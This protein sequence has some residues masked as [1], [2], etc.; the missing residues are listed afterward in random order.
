MRPIF[1]FLISDKGKGPLDD[2]KKNYIKLSFK[3]GLDPDFLMQL[4]DAIIL[5]VWESL[6]ANS[7][8]I[9]LVWSFFLQYIAS[10][11]V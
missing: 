9:S 1:E 4:T 6:P 8:T 11:N 3:D 5:K 2:S 10:K 7:S